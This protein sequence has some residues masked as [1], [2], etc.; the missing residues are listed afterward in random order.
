M[1]KNLTATTVIALSLAACAG[2]PPTPTPV[3][4]AY[5]QQKD[6]LALQTEINANTYQ[7]SVL[8]VEQQNKRTQNVVA[9][10]AGAIL[11]WP[12]LF[13]MDFQDAA[14]TESNALQSRQGYLA[15]LAATRCSGGAVASVR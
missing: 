7:V 9:G 8:S 6:C 3:V 5:D 4:Q 15:Q 12:A 10:V 1:L 2:R 11:F 14:G 13:A